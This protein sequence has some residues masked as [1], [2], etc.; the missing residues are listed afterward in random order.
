MGFGEAGQKKAVYIV[1]LDGQKVNNIREI[2]VP[3]T[4]SLE[5]L[6][7]NMQEIFT[8]INEL[9][10]TDKTAWLDV[11]YNGLEIIAD[12]QNQLASFTK[13]FPNLEILS[14]HDESRRP[15]I[16]GITVPDGIENITP[17]EMLELLF[18]A[19]GIPPEQQE[20]FIPMYEEILRGI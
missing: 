3:C 17:L 9:G 12:I 6:K 5:Q 19:E 8:K 11:T 14:V 4:Q 10:R 2:A 1:E 15:E 13:N 20:I 7:G 18:K 16:K